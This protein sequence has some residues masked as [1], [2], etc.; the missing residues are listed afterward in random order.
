MLKTDQD[1]AHFKIFDMLSETIFRWCFHGFKILTLIGSKQY[2]CTCAFLFWKRF[3]VMC[4]LLIYITIVVS[5]FI[6]WGL[7]DLFFKLSHFSAIMRRQCFSASSSHFFSETRPWVKHRMTK[8][9]NYNYLYILPGQRSQFR[10]LAALLEDSSGM[11]SLN[12]RF[13]KMSPP[14]DAAGLIDTSKCI[15]Y[16]CFVRRYFSEL[17][18]KIK[19][20]Q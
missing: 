14:K 19:W 6:Q 7:Y 8:N 11:S 5:F 17:G 10:T 4:D 20:L 16:L 2:V 13:Q 1:N 3:K 15:R 9:I 12:I 18:V